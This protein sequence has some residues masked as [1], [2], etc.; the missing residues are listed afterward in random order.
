MSIPEQIVT[1]NFITVT[2]FNSSQDIEDIQ[3]KLEEIQ[4]A[5][6]SAEVDGMII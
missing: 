1:D 3:T 4:R 2:T 6:D 5:L